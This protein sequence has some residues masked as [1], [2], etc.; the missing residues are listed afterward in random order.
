MKSSGSG[1]KSGTSR[2]KSGSRSRSRS[3]SRNKG[4]EPTRGKT[5]SDLS[6]TD[7]VG[8]NHSDSSKVSFEMVSSSGQSIETEAD[9]HPSPD[10][11]SI[12]RLKLLGRATVGKVSVDALYLLPDEGQ[13]EKNMS[14]KL[15]QKKVTWMKSGSYFVEYKFPVVAASRDK[16]SDNT[17]ATEVIRAPSKEIEENTILFHHR[18]VFPVLFDRKSIECWWRSYLTF[19]LFFRDAQ[20]RTPTLVGSCQLSLKSVLKASSL[21]LNKYLA[22]CKPGTS[23]K[24]SRRQSTSSKKLPTIGELKVTVEI[25]SDASNFSAALSNTRLAEYSGDTRY[26]PVNFHDK[27]GSLL[28]EVTES[29]PNR[30]TADISCDTDILAERREAGLKPDCHLET[31]AAPRERQ[32]PQYI[33]STNDAP[34]LATTTTTTAATTVQANSSPT[35]Q[36]YPDVQDQTLA[37]HSILIV[38]EGRKMTFD[39]TS[40]KINPIA[41]AAVTQGGGGDGR[42]SNLPRATRNSYLVCRMFWCEQQVRSSICWRTNNPQY[43]FIQVSPVFV[44]ANFLERIRNNYLIIE[45][46]DKTTTSLE[47]SDDKLIGV[48]KLSLH[49]FYLSLRNQRIVTTLLKSPYPIVAHDGYMPIVDPLTNY[50]HGQLKVL[51]AMGSI[52]QVS[53]LQQVTIE[54]RSSLLRQQFPNLHQSLINTSSST[55]TDEGICKD[56]IEHVFEVVVEDIN[57]LQH[58]EE[59]VYGEADCFVQYSFPT[60]SSTQA[61]LETGAITDISMKTSRTGVTLCLPDPVFHAITQHKMVLPPNTPL[62]AKLLIAC[63]DSEGQ[64]N[65]ILFQVCCRFYHPVIG[66]QVIAKATL[67]LVKL[68]A[69]IS[70]Y[71]QE[72]LTQKFKLPL[73]MVTTDTQTSTCESVTAGDLNVVIRYK[74]HVKQLT[75]QPPITT[76]SESPFTYICVGILRTCGLQSAAEMCA[77]QNPDMLYP[78]KVGV[79]LYL[80]ARFSFIDQRNFTTRTMAKCFHANIGQYFDF[81][82]PLVATNNGMASCLAEQLETAGLHLELWHQNISEPGISCTNHQD[83]LLGNTFVPLAELLTSTTG[84][85]GWFPVNKPVVEDTSRLITVQTSSAGQ[86]ERVVG[87]VEV[88]IKFSQANDLDRV[89]RIA[90]MH[91]WT[92]PDRYALNGSFADL[93]NG[94]DLQVTINA[95]D[96]RLAVPNCLFPGQTT[97]NRESFTYL[98]YTFYDKGPFT[99]D[100][101]PIKAYGEDFV[102]MKAGHQNSFLVDLSSPLLWFLKEEKLEI[103][104]W[105]SV[106]ASTIPRIDIGDGDNLDKTIRSRRKPKDKLIGSVWIPL[107]ELCCGP[108][109]NVYRISGLYPIFNARAANLHGMFL[110]CHITLQLQ[111]LLPG[112]KR[113]LAKKASTTMAVDSKSDSEDSDW[114]DIPTEKTSTDHH[115]GHPRKNHQNFL[116]VFEVHISVEKAMHLKHVTNKSSGKICKPNT[117]VSFQSGY[118]NRTVSTSVVHN[119]D[120]PVWDFDVDTLLT[121]RLLYEENKNLVFKVWHKPENSS[122]DIS[123]SCD[124]VIGY[125]SVDLVP[126]VSGLHQL[127]GWY[128]I[129]DFGGQCRG[130]VKLSVTPMESMDH[131]WRRLTTHLAQQAGKQVSA[132]CPSM[133][134][135]TSNTKLPHFEEH[136]ENVKR[137]HEMLKQQSQMSARNTLALELPTFQFTASAQGDL[138]VKLREQMME[139]DQMNHALLSKL[140]PNI[141]AAV[142]AAAARYKTV[143]P[144]PPPP[145]TLTSTT[146]TT[147]TTKSSSLNNNNNNNSNSN[148]SHKCKKNLF[149]IPT[150]QSDFTLS[151][152]QD[153]SSA[154]QRDAVDLLDVTSDEEAGEKENIELNK[155]SELSPS[156]VIMSLP[157]TST[158]PGTLRSNRVI[159]S[160]SRQSQSFGVDPLLGERGSASF[161]QALSPPPPPSPPPHQHQQQT[162]SKENLQQKKS[163]ALLTEL[164]STPT[165][166]GGEGD[167]E[168]SVRGGAGISLELDPGIS[169]AADTENNNKGNDCDRTVESGFDYEHKPDLADSDNVIVLGDDSD[170]DDDDDNDDDGG[171]GNED[172]DDD[173][174]DEKDYNDDDEEEEEGSIIVPRLVN[175]VSS[176]QEGSQYHFD[177]PS[178]IV[179]IVSS[180]DATRY[181]HHHHHQQQQQQQQQPHSQHQY[182]HPNNENNSNNQ[183]CHLV[184]PDNSCTQNS[185]HEF[186]TEEILADFHRIAGHFKDHL[187]KF[188]EM[189]TTTTTTSITTIPTDAATTSNTVNAITTATTAH[190][191]TPTVISTPLICSENAALQHGSFEDANLSLLSPD[192]TTGPMFLSSLAESSLSVT[193]QNE[194]PFVEP[195]KHE[196][197]AS[198]TPSGMPDDSHFVL[199]RETTS[200]QG[201]IPD[202]AK[203]EQLQGP[204]SQPLQTVPSHFSHPQPLPLHM[205]TTSNIMGSNVAF[206]ASAVLEPCHTNAAST[207]NQTKAFPSKTAPLSR[208]ASTNFFLP[209][210]DLEQSMRAVRINTAMSTYKTVMDTF[211]QTRQDGQVEARKELVNKLSRPNADQV[212]ERETNNQKLPQNYHHPPS[213]E[214]A[215]RIAKIFSMKF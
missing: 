53:T 113:H 64:V 13:T 129:M 203:P 143:A 9:M 73:T 5:G 34:L 69:M 169:P 137:H 168:C 94:R 39:T 51:L 123:K 156:P 59:M 99:S 165:P 88:S 109:K 171:G 22:V 49:Q 40:T 175:D 75:N 38:S 80:K 126:L 186:Q 61:P 110:R 60:Q 43:D 106:G 1:R 161:G 162:L 173:D 55:T 62:Q 189:T 194:T 101:I 48:V 77:L 56:Y 68:C 177:D 17:M 200:L 41:A 147:T 107:R 155:G 206:D 112:T 131:Y 135:T 4:R 7:S 82:C 127:C 70:M 20:Q 208:L 144:P 199:Q 2:S 50:Q 133:T 76:T 52:E 78:A 191:T 31:V 84:I 24:A 167:P 211:D 83:V 132:K 122:K 198:Q 163:M 148:K 14:R 190:T 213:H 204:Y 153:T 57:N 142:A 181:N 134:A 210:P 79:N 159:T 141:S 54:R 27:K 47:V 26:V 117:Y 72:P 111:D 193:L 16:H 6:D 164:L 178:A 63:V 184:I 81:Y 98:K 188:T 154:S 202:T 30:T 90:E 149:S 42:G 120:C 92:L 145:P 157:H 160:D 87:G 21:C 195:Y 89:I 185:L 124:Q 179:Q 138:K 105:F 209:L 158:N 97:I 182:P 205:T 125:I 23:L 102:S 128:N 119:T 85:N 35:S 29:Q 187:F 65:D 100:A 152:L 32:F 174:D 91:N 121:S 36:H 46:W 19:K 130:Q 136:Y 108:K 150:S 58:L 196:G 95:D 118:K 207:V 166:T 18:S 71:K 146:T 172:V 25:G 15:R 115:C 212:S 214:E 192:N 201:P 44:T 67:P 10:S 197:S 37:V 170:D 104:V 114:N 180:D 93:T 12:A 116:E 3:R 140:S 176:I 151:S 45:V 33:S 96:M 28:A 11:L 74:T 139:L 66:D 8:T 103:K 215:H 86:L 183:C